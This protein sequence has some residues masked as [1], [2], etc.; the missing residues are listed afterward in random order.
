MCD[1]KISIPATVVLPYMFS[2]AEMR[3]GLMRIY[4]PRKRKTR[5]YAKRQIH[6]SLE[7]G[8]VNHAAVRDFDLEAERLD[9]FAAE[10]E[11]E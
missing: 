5:E 7:D 8:S 11:A 4:V 10:L 9:Q 1:A 6:A 3:V 2:P